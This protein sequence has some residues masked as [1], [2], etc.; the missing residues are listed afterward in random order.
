ML[1]E[2]K[3]AVLIEVDLPLKTVNETWQRHWHNNCQIIA[4]GSSRGHT[5]CDSGEAD[6]AAP[7]LA[8]VFISGHMEITLLACHQQWCAD[9]KFWSALAMH[10]DQRSTSTVCSNMQSL[11][12]HLKFLFS[13][14]SS[15]NLYCKMSS[16]TRHHYNVYFIVVARNDPVTCNHSFLM[17]FSGYQKQNSRKVKWRNIM[18]D[19]SFLVSLRILKFC[20]SG[21][22]S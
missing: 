15:T 9:R 19:I 13:Y 20:R 17:F 10:L 18:N 11:G 4:R 6:N 7:T 5:L 2:T 14:T 3:A 16:Y 1:H 21:S 22:A 8:V 12:P